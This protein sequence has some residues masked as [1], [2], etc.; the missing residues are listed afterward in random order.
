MPDNT[1]LAFNLVQREDFTVHNL[2][3]EI[4]VD[5]LSRRLL[6]AIRDVL[7]E[8]GDLSPLQVGK[9]CHGADLFLRD[10]V[11]ATCGDNLFHLPPERVRQFAGH[12]YIVNTL[13][14]NGAELAV[15]LDG[16]AAC[17]E[18]LADQG[19][20]ERT[21]YAAILAACADLPGYLQ[22]IEDFWAISADGYDRWRAACPLPPRPT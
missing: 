9:L 10:F 3:D 22:R 15:I 16:I 1:L 14:P 6:L 2:D 13:E 7:L 19:L 5:A 20:V 12:W 11:V 21:R 4:R 8:R 17:Y 18:V